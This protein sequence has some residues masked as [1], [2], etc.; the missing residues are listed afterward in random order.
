MEY[1]NIW[2]SLFGIAG[3]LAWTFDY[4]NLFKKSPFKFPKVKISLYFKL[5]HKIIFILGI[6]GWLLIS[7][8]LTGPR[9]PQKFMPDTIEVNDIIIVLDVSR[10]MLADDLKPNR[11]EVAKKRLREFASLKPKDRIGIIIFSEKVFTLLPPTTDPSLVDKIL[12]EINIGHLGAG[13]NIGDA[14]ALGV[15]RAEAS[16]TKNKVIV[17]L[18]DG[19]SNVGSMTPL[20]AAEVA[21]DF[22]IKV[23]TIAIGTN[24]DARLPIGNGIFGMQYQT[25]PGGSIDVKSLQQISN[26]TGGKSYLA[27]SNESFK[28]ILSDIEKLER[29]K[30]KNNN[31]VVYDE[32]YF[33]YLFWGIIFLFGTELIRRFILRE[34]I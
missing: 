8:S 25:I 11:L 20:Q 30:I 15:A 21:K 14:L 13:T 24:E 22:K 3:L 5:I 17:L 18:T 6:I 34:V 2:Y 28:E 32:L 10:S 4:F 29:T 31:Q 16:E 27:N 26:M 7:F 23:Y 1:N 19:V 33:K 12:S 9:K